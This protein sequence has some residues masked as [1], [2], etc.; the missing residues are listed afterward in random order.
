MSPGLTEG[1]DPSPPRYDPALQLVFTSAHGAVSPESVREFYRVS[2]SPLG[3]SLE[4]PPNEEQMAFRR[5]GERLFLLIGENNGGTL[6]RVRL[7]V[8]DGVPT[9]D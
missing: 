9:A 6:L 4:S 7:I 8:N 3:W 5:G 1:P 2:L